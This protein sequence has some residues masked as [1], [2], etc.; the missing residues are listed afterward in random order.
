VQP[1]D[2]VLHILRRV[3]SPGQ[4]RHRVLEL[5]PVDHDRGRQRELVGLARVIEMQVSVQDISHVCN[6]DPVGSELSVE[7][8][9]RL[10]E[11]SQ[12]DP[13]QDVRMPEP[14]VHDDDVLGTHKQEALDRKA[15]PN[16]RRPRCDGTAAVDLDRTEI[17]NFDV[18]HQASASPAAGTYN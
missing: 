3:T 7:S 2:E 1:I 17:Q 13:L 16:T 12:P 10:F 15:N 5:A 18:P 8:L 9:P 4:A 14:R 6:P 11:A